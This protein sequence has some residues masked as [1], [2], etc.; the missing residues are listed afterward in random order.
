MTTTTHEADAAKKK[1]ADEREKRQKA[2][3]EQQERLAKQR[4]TPTQDENDRRALGETFT[5]HEDDGSGPDPN[6]TRQV[7]AAKPAGGGYGTRSMHR[8]HSASE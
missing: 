2:Q 4:P 7:E 8:G 1:A 5:E 6:A 3:Q